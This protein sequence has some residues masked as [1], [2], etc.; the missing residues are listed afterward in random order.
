MTRAECQMWPGFEFGEGWVG[1]GQPRVSSLEG[2]CIFVIYL[3]VYV[4]VCA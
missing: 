1:L 4:Y 3:V 2:P